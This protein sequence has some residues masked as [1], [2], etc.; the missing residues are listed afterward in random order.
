MGIMFPMLSAFTSCFFATCNL[1][2]VI[3][4][5]HY[6]M[7]EGMLN[8]DSEVIFVSD[9]EGAAESKAAWSDPDHYEEGTTL[10]ILNHRLT[11]QGNQR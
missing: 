11:N 7:R 1:F 10:F 6:A 5:S 4:G 3:Q 2:R 8:C 9:S